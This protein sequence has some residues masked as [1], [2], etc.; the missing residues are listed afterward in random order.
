MNLGFRRERTGLETRGNLPRH[1]K[2]RFAKPR[3]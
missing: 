1:T 3:L 2:S